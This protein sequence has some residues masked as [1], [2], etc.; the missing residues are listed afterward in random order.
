MELKD[1]LLLLGGA[2]LGAQLM[3]LEWM[4]WLHKHD[5]RH[6]FDKPTEEGK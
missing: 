5:L 4:R 1:V 6:R 3:N 2:T